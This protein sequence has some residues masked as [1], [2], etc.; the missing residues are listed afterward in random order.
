VSI[1]DQIKT[2]DL[3][4]TQFCHVGKIIRQLNPEDVKALQELFDKKVS[5][6]IISKILV[7]EGYS[8]SKDAVRVHNAKECKCESRKA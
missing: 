8:T 6:Q 5:Y 1:K 7:A 3:E 4:S 2:L